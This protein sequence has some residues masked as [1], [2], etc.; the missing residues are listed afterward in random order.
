[1]SELDE[2]GEAP[3][4]IAAPTVFGASGVVG[5]VR[6]RCAECGIEVWLAPSSQALIAKRPGTLVLCMTCGFAR[7]EAA[8]DGAQFA[9]APGAYTEFIARLISRA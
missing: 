9:T 8:T 4:I 7:A 3:V 2:I 1:M 5:S 6:G